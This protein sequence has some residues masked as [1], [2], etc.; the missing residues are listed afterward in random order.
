MA[1]A[2]RRRIIREGVTGGLVGGGT[3][4]AGQLLIASIAGVPPGTPWQLWSSLVLGQ[5]A[6]VGDLSLLRF[7][8][9]FVIHFGLSTAFGLLFS[10][11]VAAISRPMRNDLTVQLGGGFIYGMVLWLI[12]YQLI[13]RLFFPWFAALNPGVQ[14]MAHGLFYGLPLATWMAMMLRDLEVPGVHEA[15]HRYQ[16][17][18]GDEELLR[19]QHH[20]DQHEEASEPQGPHPGMRLP[21][22]AGIAEPRPEDREPPQY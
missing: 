19:L 10:L 11:V 8:L 4:A 5:G 21:S 14:L 2:S 7:I 18:T 6:L 15:R 13:G 9:G 17:S 22:G 1:V 20:W 12:N 16:T 3:L